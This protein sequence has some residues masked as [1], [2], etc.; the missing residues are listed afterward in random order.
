V[1]ETAVEITRGEVLKPCIP[2][3]FLET[4]PRGIDKIAMPLPSLPGGQE[5]RADMRSAL[6]KRPD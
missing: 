2:K 6:Y 5:A 3:V 1:I 4:S